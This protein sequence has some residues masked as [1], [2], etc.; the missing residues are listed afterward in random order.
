M[1]TPYIY[2]YIYSFHITNI[3]CCIL[4]IA[5]GVEDKR[6]LINATEEGLETIFQELRNST[7]ENH[8]NTV[9]SKATNLPTS[10]QGR[11]SP[12]MMNSVNQWSSKTE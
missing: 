9:R 7:G 10:F 6:W 2:I 3:D 1:T 5:T 11:W 12:R 8:K 4:Y